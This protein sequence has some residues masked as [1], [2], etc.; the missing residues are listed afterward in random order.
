MGFDVFQ[1]RDEVVGEYREYF[2]SFVN[3][4]DPRLDAYVRKTLHQGELWP[5]GV[6]QLNPAYEDGPTLGALK[7]D[8]IIHADTA[9]FFGAPTRLRKHQAEALTIAQQREPYVVSTGTGSGKSLT[10]LL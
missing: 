7:D 9:R 4:L 5:E 3:V 10:Y 6:L 2:E 8:A 1:L